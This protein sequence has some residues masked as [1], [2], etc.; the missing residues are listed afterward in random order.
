MSFFAQASQRH[1]RHRVARL[2][3]LLLACTPLALANST[4]LPQADIAVWIEEDATRE[5]PQEPL[6]P[7]DALFNLATG[8]SASASKTAA[9]WLRIDVPALPL[10]SPERVLVIGP[11]YLDHAVLY[12]SGGAGPELDQAILSGDALP[13]TE[14]P[15]TH[16][17]HV[18][19]LGTEAGRYYL[20]ASSD[21]VLRVEWSIQ[22]E[23]AFLE[24][25]RSI[26]LGYAV[27]LGILTAMILFNLGVLAGIGDRTYMYYVAYHLSAALIIASLA[28]YAAQ[29]L[30]PGASN[31]T[32]LSIPTALT[33]MCVFGFLFVYSFIDM[34]HFLPLLARRMR[35]AIGL[36]ALLAIPGL[37][38]P[39]YYGALFTYFGCAV[40]LGAIT[41]MV[42]AAMR[43]GVR[44]AK[45]VALTFSLTI[46]PGSLGAFLY[47]YGAL[48]ENIIFAHMLEVTTAVETLLLSLFMAYRIKVSEQE[49]LIA[50]AET[51]ELQRDFNQRMLAK[52]EE[53]RSRIA[54]EL[55]DS[56]GPNL[57][58]LS[59][60]L[61]SINSMGS[62]TKPMLSGEDA[63][64]LLRQSISE[65]RELSHSLHP[66]QLDRLSLVSAIDV[67]CR[68][69]HADGSLEFHTALAVP[70]HEIAEDKKIHLY[71]IAQEAVH[72]VASHSD[73]SLCFLSLQRKGDRIALSIRD[74]GRG[75]VAGA[76]PPEG[77]G[78]TSMSDRANIIGA[79]LEVESQPG[80]GTTIN[81]E[82]DAAAV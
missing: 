13:Y 10:H 17:L 39:Y 12:R 2:F 82:F 60:H 27:L 50:Q 41:H 65:V 6:P 64:A 79:T 46:F 19:P 76:Q 78:M 44:T 15:Y 7:D 30:W 26:N 36:V 22:A 34:P 69:F 45:F 25:H 43:A 9:V 21:G 59:I 48:P 57:S 56:V 51:L 55:H 63:L 35:Q 54:R 77:L 53:D 58:A 28:G 72:N 31:S 23:S 11:A 52:Q 24:T 37:L 80:E 29:Y 3:V 68:Q 16:R 18:F 66:S 32:N 1:I 14:K 40:T 4:E 62:D 73:A 33:G 67:Y 5:I 42:I 20:R 71:R 74:N 49:K 61:Q 70:E 8:A 47:Q 75:F 81:V 38:L